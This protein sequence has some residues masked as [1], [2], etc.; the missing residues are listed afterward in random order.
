MTAHCFAVVGDPVG[1]SAS[2]RMHRAAFA[3][4]GL[5]CSY[6]AIHATTAELAAVVARLRAGDLAGLN[7]TVPHK[8]SVLSY[9]DGVDAS[10]RSVGAANTLVRS[11]DGQIVAYNTDVLAVGAE[12]RALASEVT[13]AGWHRTRALILGTGATARS[14]S[15]ALAR[16]LGVAEITLRGRSLANPATRA[17][18]ESEIRSLLAAASPASVL[19]FEPWGAQDATE[20][21]VSVVVQ[22]TSLGMA[23]DGELA[24][25]AVAWGSLAES[26]VA[27]D[28]VYSS[29][30]TPF[31]RRAKAHG[32]RAADGHGMLARQGALAFELWH[33]RPA[34]SSAMRAA[35]MT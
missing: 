17:A 14:A 6:E 3:A 15:V 19:R 5:D 12:L 24:A 25:A 32:I 26:S 13:D 27:L 16:D 21:R 11:D 4:L 33:R 29:D 7:I 2:P 31:V 10:A 34:P 1:H 22:A 28:V 30:E 8:R 9:V 18:F 20:R 23:G 35:L